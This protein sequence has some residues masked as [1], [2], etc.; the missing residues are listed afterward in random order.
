MPFFFSESDFFFPC[1][2]REGPGNR[3]K[4]LLTGGKIELWFTSTF[5]CDP[6]G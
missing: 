2:E 6:S 4:K 3:L 5:L 1:K